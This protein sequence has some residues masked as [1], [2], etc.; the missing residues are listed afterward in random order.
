MRRVV[1]QK[2]AGPNHI[3]GSVIREYTDQ[4]TYISIDIFNTTLEQAVVPSC[5]KSATI[6]SVSPK[7]SASQVLMI[8]ALLQQV[9]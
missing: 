7:N 9:P 1:V 2:V 6:I 3:Q 4:L 5:F 8:T